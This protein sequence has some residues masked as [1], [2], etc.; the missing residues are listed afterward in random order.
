MSPCITSQC[1]PRISTVRTGQYFPRACMS[2][3]K[4]STEPSRRPVQKI[5]Q[6]LHFGYCQGRFRTFP[7]KVRESGTRRHTDIQVS[8]QDCAR[9]KWLLRKNVILPNSKS[10]EF[11]TCPRLL[12]RLDS[13]RDVSRKPSELR[14]SSSRLIHALDP[15]KSN[16]PQDGPRLR[17]RLRLALPVRQRGQTRT[18]EYRRAR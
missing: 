4:T 1:A 18:A 16:R 6:R 3:I 9:R 8:M 7:Q 11:D 17:L 10:S 15:Q 5:T 12:P 2:L 14:Q 13:E